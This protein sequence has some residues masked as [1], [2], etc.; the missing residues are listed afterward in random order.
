M[1]TRPQES[2]HP[3]LYVR[4]HVLPRGLTVTEAA[5]RMNVGRPALSN[6]LNGRAA[7]SPAMAVRLERTFG[8]DR[9][10]LLDLQTRFD[11]R[12]APGG[13]RAITAATY[14]PTVLAVK[15][16]DID[17]WA[18]SGIE[19]RHKLAEFIRRLVNSTGRELSKVDFPANDHAER[20]GW[21]GEVVASAPTPWIPEGESGWE[22]SCNARPRD[23]ANDDFARRTK[24]VPPRERRARTF[25]FATPRDW[26]GKSAWVDEKAR[27]GVWNAV[28]AYD[29]SDL[30]QWIEQSVPVQIW[31]AERLGRPVDGYR[32]LSRFWTEWASAAELALSPQLFAPAVERNSERFR[33][34][35]AQSP[36]RPFTIAADSRDE[37]IAFLACLMGREG[38][39]DG[40]GDRGIVFDNPDA[41]HR[42]ASAAPGAFVAVAGNTEVEKASSGFC[43]NI[44]CVVPRP[45]NSVDVTGPP[46]DVVLELPGHEDFRNA[47]EAMG[48]RRGRAD[49]LAV[50]SARSPTILRRRLSVVPAVRRARLGAGPGGRPER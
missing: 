10:A 9:E 6:F 13:R 37:A 19:P 15:A 39:D 22:L 32:S 46:V 26:P 42:L 17:A 35:L 3:G 2:T 45:R 28:R 36:A 31:F 5:K 38:G 16:R 33:A 21:D 48:V 23:K 49:R 20:R 44:H 41:L 24:S 29:A 4:E 7:L 50:E 25:V 34:W 11:A 40:A 18:S 43:R 14:A 12:E 1:N 27:L 8:A 47:L 30:E